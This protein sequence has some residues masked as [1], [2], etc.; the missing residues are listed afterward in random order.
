MLTKAQVGKAISVRANYTDLSGTAESVTSSATTAV[1]PFNNATTGTVSLSGTATQGQT[2]TAAN[3]LADL[4]GIPATGT[5][6]IAY[7]WLAD[8]VA[9]GGASSS[10]LVLTQAQVGKA[11]S[12]R[13]SYTDLG[14]TAESK[15]SSATAAVANLNDAATGAVTLS[16]TATQGQTL[17]AAHTLADVDG[18]PST[19]AG[20]ISYQ[21]LADGVAIGGAS[22]S[23]LMLTQAQVGKAISVRASYTDLGGTAES[24]TSNATAAVAN[25]NDAAT[26]AVTLSGTATQGQTLTAANTLADLD[27]IPT[28]GIGA[29]AYQWLADGVAIGSASSSTLVLTQAQV[30]KAISVRASYT[31]LQGTAESVTSSATA[32]VANIKDI[33][34]PTASTFSPADEATAVAIGANVV[35][36][37]SE[38]V[39]R[40]AGSILL[41][42]TDGTTVATYTQASTEVTVSGSTLTINPASDL[43]YGTG[44]KVEF[45][46]G[47]V[48]DLAGNSYAGTT[49]YNFTTSAVPVSSQFV[50]FSGVKL[51]KDVAGGKS[52][53]NLSISFAGSS[54]DG[55]KIQGAVLDLDYDVS[56]VASATVSGGQYGPD[57]QNVWET[58]AHNLKG[59]SA[60]GKIAAVVHEDPLNPLVVNGKTIDVTLVLNQIVDS[61]PIGFNSQMAEV[62]TSDGIKHL[63][64]TSADVTAVPAPAYSLKTSSVFWKSLAGGTSKA[65]PN[66]NFTK[67][68]QTVKS[69]GNGEVTLDAIE[70]PKVTISVAKPVADLE[71]ASV[72]AAVNLTDAIAILKMIVGLNV[73]ASGI[74]TSPYQVVAA[75]YNRDGSVGL[76]DA[77]DVLKSVV[78][79]SAPAPSWVLLDQS[80]VT[81]ALSM[82]DYNAD[83]N[84]LSAGAW[85]S[86]TLSIDLEKTPEVKLVGVLAGDVD[87]SWAG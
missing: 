17:T 45:A 14:G 39:L 61:F 74:Q 81:S 12:V 59:A 37:F 36:T 2:L 22:S 44:Y 13:A 4:D 55:S 27:G 23:T 58:F 86:S 31:D 77:I 53:V 72:A 40:G 85:M 21:W 76:S 67:T 63:V 52:T 9:I 49:S 70:D 56:K 50:S 84:K 83:T 6:A 7:Q 28:S 62:V 25:V 69:D 68:A 3:T 10:T 30:G 71:K 78:G 60:N 73:N 32:A 64:S 75:D 54:I 38:A 79:L 5:G 46:A 35:V 47:S 57:N 1:A 15:T 51:T 11:V 20:A 41:K 87:G 65:L 33:D 42:K 8:G 43:A 82:N 29:I 48:Q 26:G 24:K 80:K 18:I 66:V 16:G 19:G 34:V